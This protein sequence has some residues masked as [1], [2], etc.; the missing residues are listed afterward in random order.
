VAFSLCLLPSATAQDAP[1]SAFHLLNNFDIPM[2]A[3]RSLVNDKQVSEYTEWTAASDITHCRFY[4]RTFHDSNI[5]MVELTRCNLDAKD[6][7]TL[8]LNQVEK[9]DDMTVAGAASGD[10]RAEVRAGAAGR[11]RAQG[12]G[13]VAQ[14]DRCRVARSAAEGEEDTAHPGE[15]SS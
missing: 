12:E 13:T 7:V 1:L 14:E 9:I 6:V 5:R 10:G 2:G 8:E 3:N 4:V 15:A 11:D